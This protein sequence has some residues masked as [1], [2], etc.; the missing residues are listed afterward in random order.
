DG[1]FGLVEYV[2]RSISPILSHTW[3]ADHD[4]VTFSNIVNCTCKSKPSYARIRFCGK[5][6]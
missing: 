1:E 6:A 4:E 3:E 5:Q 2:G